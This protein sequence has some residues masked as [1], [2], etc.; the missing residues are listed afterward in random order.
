MRAEEHRTLGGQR[1]KKNSPKHALDK[2]RFGEKELSK[3]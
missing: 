1:T 2:A 3:N